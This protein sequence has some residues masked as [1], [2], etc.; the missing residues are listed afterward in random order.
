MLKEKKKKKKQYVFFVQHISRPILNS[1][2]CN[3]TIR[4]NERELKQTLAK[5][6]ENQLHL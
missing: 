2:Y 6:T 4:L 5:S 1:S 3:Y